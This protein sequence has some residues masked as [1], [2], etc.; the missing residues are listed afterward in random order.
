MLFDNG[1]TLTFK[2]NFYK[3]IYLLKCCINSFVKRFTLPILRP[4]LIQGN[5]Y[6]NK[7]ESTLPENAS[8][9]V[10]FFMVYGF[11]PP[12]PIS[13]NHDFNKIEF[14]LRK[15]VSTQLPTYQTKLFLKRK[16]L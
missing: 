16:D 10:S 14:S 6:L 3:K 15:Y 2:F 4:Q 8:T 5:P 11:H 13:M 7:L 1:S 9:E 12:L